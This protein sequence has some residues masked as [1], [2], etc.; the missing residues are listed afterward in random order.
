[1]KQAPARR[2]A[3]AGRGHLH[4]P[5]TQR[6]PGFAPGP[7]FHTGLCGKPG[8][9]A[10]W[11][12]ERG[13]VEACCSSRVPFGYPAGFALSAAGSSQR[14]EASVIVTTVLSG[15]LSVAFDGLLSTT[16]NVPFGSSVVSLTIGC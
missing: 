16:I 10:W 1:M 8:V 9:D 6:V 15:V 11:W 4:P 12:A 5:V 2:A 7:Q 13:D 14:R 3:G